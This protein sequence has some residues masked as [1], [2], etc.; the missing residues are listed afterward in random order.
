MLTPLPVQDLSV[1]A[2]A[3]YGQVI[4]PSIDGQAYGEDDAQLDLRQGTPRFY[5][6]HLEHRGRQFSDITRHERCTQC[7]GSLT[8]D[9]PWYLAVAPPSVEPE[10]D[11]QALQAFRIIGP[12]FIKLHVGTWHAGPF[13][14]AATM[15]FYNLELSDTNVVDH[16]T[17]NFEQQQ[18]K[19][20]EFVL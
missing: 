11:L 5:I 20:F 19:R 12:C 6:M 18:A 4:S 14:D 3:P 1:A 2:F 16:T 8:I 17:Y 9:Q 7:L 13:F 10:P 15:D